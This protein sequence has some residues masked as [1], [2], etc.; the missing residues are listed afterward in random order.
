MKPLPNAPPDD[1]THLLFSPDTEHNNFIS[2]P[3]SNYVFNYRGFFLFVLLS[4]EI[5]RNDT[6]LR[7]NLSMYKPRYNLHLTPCK[8]KITVNLRIHERKPSSKV[9]I[10]QNKP[11]RELAKL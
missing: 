10:A 2:I 9:I 5:N 1:T 8:H 7:W 11:E 3:K 4:A 6:Y